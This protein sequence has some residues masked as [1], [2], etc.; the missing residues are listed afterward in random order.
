MMA[1]PRIS[2]EGVAAEQRRGTAVARLAHE[3]GIGHLVYSSISG[4]DADTG[5]S[6]Y[7]SKARIEAAIRE[8]GLPAT[9]LRPVSFMDNFASYNRPVLRDGELV[10][11]LA[12]APDRPAAFIA[13][14]DI[15]AF[16]AIAF[17]YR[18]EFLGR[19]LTIAGD[20]LTPDQIAETFE[21][22]GGVPTRYHRTPIA[23]VRAMDEQL[24][25]I[26]SYFDEHPAP[27]VDLAPLR[28]YHP[29][30]VRLETWLLT[31]GWRPPEPVESEKPR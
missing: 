27:P 2:P 10:V 8:L 20:A 5:I 13:V 11:N 4:A 24:A 25:T 29:G 6:Y 16:A 30:L 21:R 26:F 14:D 9:I 19:S 23:Q 22:V 3:A 28:A 31:T 7:E 1:G 18:D 17:A 12:L 15:G